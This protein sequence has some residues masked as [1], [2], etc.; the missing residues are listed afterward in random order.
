MKREDIVLKIFRIG[1]LVVPGIL[2]L[3]CILYIV[4]SILIV[5]GMQDSAR[6]AEEETRS[7]VVERIDSFVSFN[8]KLP[9]TLSELGFRQTAAAYDFSFADVRKGIGGL[10]E[11]QAIPDRNDSSYI[12]MFRYERG[13]HESFYFS[14]YGEWYDVRD[15]PKY[16]KINDTL[17]AIREIR[18]KLKYGLNSDKV[19]VERHLVPNQDISTADR[20]YKYD[21]L[22]Y[23]CYRHEDTQMSME[24]WALTDGGSSLYSSYEEYGDW[25]YC[26]E[27]GNEYHKFWNYRKNDTLIFK[28][29]PQPKRI[30]NPPSPTGK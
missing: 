20:D 8:G 1:C 11:F 5:K 17:T 21:S 29:D 26:D 18:W 30:Y 28:P 12:L 22:T 16:F 10:Y 13:G 24:G 6:M 23:L 3:C 27:D 4:L 19:S 9:A 25:R 7:I 14:R 15:N 2:I